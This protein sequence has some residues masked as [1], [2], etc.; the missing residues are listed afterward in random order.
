[1]RVRDMRSNCRVP[2]SKVS[3]ETLWIRIGASVN[4]SPIALMSKSTG[5]MWS[6]WGVPHGSRGAEKPRRCISPCRKSADALMKKRSVLD[7]TSDCGVSYGNSCVD[8]PWNCI[9]PYGN[10]SAD[11][12]MSSM[13]K[14]WGS[15]C[16]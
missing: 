16:T 11:A 13:E 3:V 4:K 1:M 9:G 15:I 12:V 10:K 7:F 6:N 8:K 14:P 2:D 5:D